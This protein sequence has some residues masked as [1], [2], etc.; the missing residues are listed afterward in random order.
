MKLSRGE[1]QLFTFI[2]LK[3]DWIW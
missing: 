3:S 1:K 2:Y